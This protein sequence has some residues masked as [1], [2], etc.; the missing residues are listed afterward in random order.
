MVDTKRGN[1]AYKRLL[2]DI[3]RIQPTAQ[4]NLYD[5]GIGRRVREKARKAAAVVTSKKLACSP[6]A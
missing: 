1:A 5:A 6:S 3:G 2:D 4:T